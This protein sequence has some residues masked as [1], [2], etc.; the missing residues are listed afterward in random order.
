MKI[1]ISSPSYESALNSRL[2]GHAPGSETSSK[3]LHWLPALGR[4]FMKDRANKT[5]FLDPH[6]MCMAPNYPRAW[7]FPET[8]LERLFGSALEGDAL[9]VESLAIATIP[10]WIPEVLARSVRPSI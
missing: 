2:R 5:A 6:I 1:C 9:V 3:G 7:A 4:Q 10:G 8:T